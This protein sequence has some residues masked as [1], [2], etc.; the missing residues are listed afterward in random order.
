MSKD[1][2]LNVRMPV[3]DV[4]RF[5]LKCERLGRPQSVVLR[6]FVEAFNDGRLK[7][8]PTENQKEE[9]KEMYDVN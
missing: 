4:E 8:L 9:M 6:E 2:M 1:T 5:K 7:I 3:A